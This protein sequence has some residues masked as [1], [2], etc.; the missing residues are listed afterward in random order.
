MSL[1]ATFIVPTSLQF[2]ENGVFIEVMSKDPMSIAIKKIL[3]KS[4]SHNF[5]EIHFLYEPNRIS[6]VYSN[7]LLIK[8]VDTNTMSGK[9]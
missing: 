5:L 8:S 6:I 1:P 3:I 2:I 4:S 7:V 9:K